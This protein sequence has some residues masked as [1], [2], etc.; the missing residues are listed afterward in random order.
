MSGKIQNLL[1]QANSS[2]ANDSS[3]TFAKRVFS[4]ETDAEKYFEKVKKALFDLE[5]WDKNS[6]PSSYE[7]F[8]EA[9]RVRESKI[10]FLGGFIRI[11]I[12]GSGKYDWIK[13]IEIYDAPNEFVIRVE[14]TYD[15][16]KKPA[17][18]TV[19]SHFFTNESTNNFCLQRDGKEII[20]YVIGLKE[21]TNTGQ[22]GGTIETIRNVAAAN[23]G[24]YFG[25]QKA[26][27][28]I[29]CAK[30]LEIGE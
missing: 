9:G 17:D 21:K 2:Q 30:F 14:P 3:V 8:D 18:K 7:L 25:I 4:I 5:I 15:P 6:T 24:Y 1:E 22:T 11:H 16:T 23:S 28:K 27:W 19:T 29:F 20:L 10:I 13:V 12:T 26:M